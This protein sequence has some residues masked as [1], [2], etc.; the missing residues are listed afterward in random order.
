MLIE[1]VQELSGYPAPAR[2]DV[3]DAEAQHPAAS[4]AVPPRLATDAGALSFISTMTVFGTPV[5]IS[6]AE[7]ALE[8]F[9]RRTPPPQQLQQ[10]AQ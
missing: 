4:V 8:S 7:L 6:L 5:D 10:L 2:T 9:S 3:H 1:L